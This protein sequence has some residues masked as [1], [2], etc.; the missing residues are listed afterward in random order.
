M[1]TYCIITFYF[2]SQ[3]QN[4]P[5]CATPQKP[6]HGDL[7]LQ[8]KESDILSSV[9]YLC[10]KPYKLKGASQRAC[11]PN[12]TWSGSAPVCIKGTLTLM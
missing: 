6:A 9:Q 4:P 1:L 10:Y 3:G 7:F 5:L 12:G 11:L 8:Y 2:F